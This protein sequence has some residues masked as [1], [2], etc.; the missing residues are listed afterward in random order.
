MPLVPPPPPLPGTPGRPRTSGR[1]PGSL[2][3]PATGAPA[4]DPWL[5]TPTSSA[6]RSGL[7]SPASEVPPEPIGVEG[8]LQQMLASVPQHM[9][10]ANAADAAKDFAAVLFGYMF[11]E[12]RPH[13]DKDG[14]LGGGDSEMFMEFFDEAIGRDMADGPGN[15]LVKA[16]I[17]ELT[18][19]SSKSSKSSKSVK[20]AKGR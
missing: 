11:S 3:T 2:S 12:M 18:P 13:E 15:P 8:E 17:Q 1:S 20:P 9:P 6:A 16:L 4:T 14:L 7:T 19:E 5:A 10:I